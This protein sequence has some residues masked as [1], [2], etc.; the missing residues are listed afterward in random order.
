LGFAFLNNVTITKNVGVGG[1]GRAGGLNSTSGAT[2]VVKNSIIAD[3]QGSGGATNDCAGA[4]TTD[5]VY[6]LIRDPTG[7]VLP[8]IEQPPDPETFILNED[9]RL[10]ELAF[11]NG[12]TRNHLPAPDSPVIDAGFPF[13]PGGPAADSCEPIDQR[14]V[15][16][17]ICDIGAVEREVQ[18]PTALTVTTTADEVDTRPG[19]GACET[20]SNA[21]SLR[22]AVQEANQLP[23]SQTITVPAGT[24]D[25]SIPPEDEGGFDPAAGGDLDL[26]GNAI[27]VGAGRETVI[28]DG[29]DLSRIFDVA[30][31]ATAH[32][33]GMT[34]RDGT[35]LGGGGVRLLT[36]SLTLDDVL[37]EDNESQSAGG[38]IEVGGL[39]AVLEIRDSIVRNNRAPFFGGDGGG[40]EATGQITINRTR[41]IGNQASGSGG[42]LSGRGVVNVIGSTIANNRATSSIFAFGGGISAS[43]LNLRQSTVSGNAADRQ[44]GG[45]FASGSIVNSTV[46]GNT[47]GT[48]GGGVSTSGT[49]TLLHVTIANNGATEGGNGLF[50][51]GSGS[52]LSLQNTILADA[53]GTECAGLP[54][55]SKGNNIASDASCGLTAG[56]DKQR[57]AA[58]LNPLAS[59]GGP[60]LT[61]SP[62]STS[63]AVNAAADVG[64][65]S[66]QRG[67]RRPL[68]P[69]PD[70]GAVER[71]P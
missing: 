20:A 63:P 11:N 36:G 38:G 16:R 57:T 64:L 24:Y 49:L 66:D 43:G 48:S 32:I 41:I 42:G 54:P 53:P 46:S 45:V 9:P 23:G 13:P 1:G 10:G 51:F 40:I 14:G 50:R 37:V 29:N 56:G 18:V 44:G 39:D 2:T 65:R 35:D 60:T 59:N 71:R 27:V 15:P 8:P 25:L 21:C 4:L 30:P 3:N 28:V 67:V 17:L 68:G 58:R 6:N 19:N 26:I 12:P 62:R 22:A 31:G 61:H 70:I 33:S 69:R 7:C 55:T 5:S 47:S 34:V 52:E